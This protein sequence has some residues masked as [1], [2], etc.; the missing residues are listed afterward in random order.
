[1]ASEPK[2][3]TVMA[4]LQY[5]LCQTI[6][7]HQLPLMRRSQPWRRGSATQAVG[8]SRTQLALL[9]NR[10]TVDQRTLTPLVLVRIQVP[11]PTTSLFHPHI[12]QA[13]NSCDIS[14]GW[15]CVR[16]LMPEHFGAFNDFRPNRRDFVS[17]G[18]L[19]T[20]GL[21]L[22]VGHGTGK[23]GVQPANSRRCSAQSRC[24][25]AMV[26]RSPTVRPSG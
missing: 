5:R 10:L 9:G 14:V 21:A 6:Q 13:S 24:R 2:S 25:V 26:A 3:K 19:G 1:M 4:M 18:K 8:N 17:T 7:A 20:Y 12:H 23:T 22:R 15:R 16:L 11:Q